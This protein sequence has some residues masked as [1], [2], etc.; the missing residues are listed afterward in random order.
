MKKT[1]KL[2]PKGKLIEAVAGK[3]QRLV[4]LKASDENGYCKCVSCGVVKHYKDG[5]QGG[6]FI[7]RGCSETRLLEENIHPQCA[8][9]N[10]FGMKYGIASQVYTL[11]MIDMYGKDFVD[12]L[13][14]CKRAKRVHKVS[15]AELEDMLIDFKKQI[16][17]HEKRVL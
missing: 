16:K 5:M 13:L 4:R 7:P 3:L 2:K 15:R 14:G 1:K 17:E 9:C 12:Y 6:H 10:G 11:Y 8:G